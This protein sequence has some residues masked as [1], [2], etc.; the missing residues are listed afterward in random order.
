VNDYNDPAIT[1]VVAATTGFMK[2]ITPAKR[3]RATSLLIPGWSVPPRV[4]LV[5]DDSIFR[6]ISTRLLQLAGCTID[7]AVDGIEA[8][9]KIVSHDYDIVLMDIMM[10]NLDGLSATRSIRQHDTWTPIIS[11]TANTADSDVREYIMSG[12]TDVLPKPLDHSVLCK[13][14]ERYCAHLKLIQRQQQQQ[15]NHNMITPSIS[16]PESSSLTTIPSVSI[17]SSSSSIVYSSQQ[18]QQQQRQEQDEQVKRQR[19]D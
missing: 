3:P 10:P 14:L 9:S 18:L 15:N 5:D 8:C 11:M 1:R 2:T 17:P 16:Y 19:I 6:R 4:L 7:V 13:L 12:M